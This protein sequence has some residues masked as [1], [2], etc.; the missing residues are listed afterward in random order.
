MINQ[1]VSNLISEK[2]NPQIID[3]SFPVCPQCNLI[4][5]P[6]QPGEICPNAKIKVEDD[7]GNKINFE[8]DEFLLMIKNIILSKTEGKRINEKKI[9][10]LFSD[11]VINVNKIIEQSD[12]N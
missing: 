9:K 12:L 2:E 11:L 4:H 1:N 7:K 8:T 10:K 6:L 3:P 5:P